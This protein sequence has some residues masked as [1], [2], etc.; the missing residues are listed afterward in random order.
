MKHGDWCCIEGGGG[1][2]EEEGEDEGGGA[3]Y[4]C[5]VNGVRYLI[6]R[7]LLFIF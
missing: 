3:M 1:D 5:V 7:P 4:V 2:L 6:F